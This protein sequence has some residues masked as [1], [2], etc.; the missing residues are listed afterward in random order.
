MEHRG[1]VIPVEVKA[2]ATGTL[3]SLHHFMH[4]RGLN[5]A[6]RLSS[7]P[8]SLVHVQV[9]DHAGN[10]IEY[11]LLSLPLYLTEVAPRWLDEVGGLG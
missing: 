3:R 6:L 7:A 10:P 1:D 11:R 5:L 9:K 4:L 8:P 2:G